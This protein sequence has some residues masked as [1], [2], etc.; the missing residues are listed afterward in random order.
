MST[1]G[2][3]D[4]AEP[5]SQEDA[6]ISSSEPLDSVSSMDATEKIIKGKLIID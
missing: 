6:K 1:L 4:E 3:E 2:V 5:E